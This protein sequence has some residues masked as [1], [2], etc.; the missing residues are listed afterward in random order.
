MYAAGDTVVKSTLDAVSLGTI[1]SMMEA[2][3]AASSALP[4]IVETTTGRG[5]GAE[6]E[7]DAGTGTVPILDV[8]ADA[9]SS[10]LVRGCSSTT[11]CAGRGAAE[12][13]EDV[14]GTGLHLRHPEDR[15]PCPSSS[16]ISAAVLLMEA[17]RQAVLCA[18]YTSPVC[19]TRYVV[20][21]APTVP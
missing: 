8:A 3:A 16:K 20:G 7:A 6:A 11:G 12:D 13:V 21:M 5:A 14:G 18:W 4:G 1:T 2:A 19:E 15:T 10:R 9:A 17:P